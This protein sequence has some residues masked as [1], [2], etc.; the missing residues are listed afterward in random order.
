MM[1]GEPGEN[2]DGHKNDLCCKN[3]LD[4][5]DGDNNSKIVLEKSSE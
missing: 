5:L 1:Q 4:S 2:S 3:N